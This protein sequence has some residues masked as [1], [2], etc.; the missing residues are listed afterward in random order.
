MIFGSKPSEGVKTDTM[1]VYDLA[2]AMDQGYD[3]VKLSLQIPEVF[4]RL[5]GR[6]NSFETIQSNVL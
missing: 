3:K 6:D 2:N 4:E 1:M 5:E